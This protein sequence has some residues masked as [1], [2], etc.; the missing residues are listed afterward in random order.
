MTR[1]L[2]TV[3]PGTDSQ[4]VGDELAGLGARSVQPP[5]AELP[6]VFVVE[7]DAE[8]SGFMAAAADVPGVVAIEPDAWRFSQPESPAPD[9]PANAVPSAPPL[10]VED[11][12]VTPE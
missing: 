5:T 3:A 11:P 7:V 8:A 2:V 12:S 9:G 1:V 4:R 10:G 6:G